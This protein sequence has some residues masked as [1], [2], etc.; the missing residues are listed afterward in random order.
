MVS[1]NF[2]QL[3]VSEEFQSFMKRNVTH[4]RTYPISSV[5]KQSSRASGSDIQYVPHCL[6]VYL[7]NTDKFL[8]MYQSTQYYRKIT[9]QTVSRKRNQDQI[10]FDDAWCWE[11]SLSV[12][13]WSEARSLSNSYVDT[14][15]YVGVGTVVIMNDVHNLPGW[16]LD[17]M[18]GQSCLSTSLY[19]GQMFTWGSPTLK[20]VNWA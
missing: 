18:Y 1:D 16:K 4:T 15:S 3:F 6:M 11:A 7:I 13:S 8:M 20:A 12:S 9:K 2:P 10:Q 19:I 14:E 17:L 5:I